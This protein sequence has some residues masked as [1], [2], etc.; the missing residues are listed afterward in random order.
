MITMDWVVSTAQ[1]VMKEPPGVG[2]VALKMNPESDAP[3]LRFLHAFVRDFKPVAVLECGVYMGT[4]T[5]HMAVANKRTQVV[6][7]DFK[8]HP[9]LVPRVIR[10]YHNAWFI[11]GNTLEARASV[12]MALKDNKLGLLFLDST[13]DGDTPRKEFKLYSPLCEDEY[14]VACDDI[15]DPRMKDFWD[16]LPGEKRELNF[17]HPSPAKNVPFPGFGVS[18]MRKNGS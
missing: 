8:P 4:A 13:H 7:I 5:A 17:L 10:V 3:Y 18:I 11:E 9:D 1:R 6:G 12:E 15:L 16:W 2:V 14:L